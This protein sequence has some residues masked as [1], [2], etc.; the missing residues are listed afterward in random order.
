MLFRSVI[1]VTS[2]HRDFLPSSWGRYLPTVWDWGMFLG[3]IGLFF[4][5]FFLFIRVLPAIAMF[6][7]RTLVQPAGAPAAAATSES[8][9]AAQRGGGAPRD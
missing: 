2:L 3:T 4:T 5:L 7:M 6:E 1:I 8:A 9:P